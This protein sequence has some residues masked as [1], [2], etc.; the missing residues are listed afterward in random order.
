MPEN[1]IDSIS[2]C[3]HLDG[4]FRVRLNK[5][6]LDGDFQVS[7]FRQ[8]EKQR[9]GIASSSARLAINWCK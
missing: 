7:L 5:E 3:A 6:W 8:M 9:W 1:E 2:K 4:K